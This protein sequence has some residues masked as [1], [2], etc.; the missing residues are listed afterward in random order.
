MS[1]RVRI[2]CRGPKVTKTDRMDFRHL[3]SS[4][5]AEV[6]VVDE[7]T[8]KETPLEDVLSVQWTVVGDGKAPLA[9]IG[10]AGPELDVEAAADIIRLDLKTDG[11]DID[12]ARATLSY[13]DGLE[14]SEADHALAQVLVDQRAQGAAQL[15]RVLEGDV[16]PRDFALASVARAVLRSGFSLE[17][18]AG[19]VALER[20]VQGE[21]TGR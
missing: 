4:D 14:P 15:Q 1:A 11:K 12:L 21:E 18:V 6:L 10:V 7:E 5:D 17:E 9:V 3:P 19:A 16:T 8:G 13:L 20:A 2:R